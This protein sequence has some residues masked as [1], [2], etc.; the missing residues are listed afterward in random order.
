[1]PRRRA[2]VAAAVVLGHV[3]LILGW[4]TLTASVD[5]KRLRPAAS[6]PPLLVRLWTD[7]APMAKRSPMAEPPP[8]R[9]PGRDEAKGARPQ[10]PA[11]QVPQA[12]AL[13]WPAPAAQ[14]PSAAATAA[15]AAPTAPTPTHAA[16]PAEPASA[17]LRLDLPRSAIG[18]RVAG[19]DRHPG[20]DDPRARS[21]VPTM[22]SRIADATA[23][24]WTEEPLG[25][26]R[27]RYRR[28]GEC[29]VTV[30]TRAGALDAFN[31]SVAPPMRGAGP[32]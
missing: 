20:L 14:P 28:G 15:E 8:S 23:A 12:A 17:P 24:T 16:L 9:A 21:A 32:C 22:A 30:P 31:Q 27:I 26:G 3:L 25:D 19:P 6:Q 4:R 2:A 29:Y 18:G 11:L 7:A 10:P 5:T 1:M 13:P